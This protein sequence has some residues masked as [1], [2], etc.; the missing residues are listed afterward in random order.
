MDSGEGVNV[1]AQPAGADK[2][3]Q[4]KT[5]EAK[6]FDMLENVMSISLQGF[7]AGSILGLCVENEPRKVANIEH[8]SNGE[9]LF[10]N[11]LSLVNY[12]CH[13]PFLF[14]LVDLSFSSTI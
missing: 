3:L 2:T 14:L 5:T 7:F 11:V 1:G 6:V 12:Y 9:H 10:S 8:I 4:E 13:S